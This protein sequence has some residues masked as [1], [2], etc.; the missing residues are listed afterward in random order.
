MIIA[1]LVLF[2]F[3]CDF[4]PPLNKEVLKAQ[5]F[6]TQR[7]YQKAAL[8]YQSILDKK[9]PVELQVKINYQLGDLYSIYLGKYDKAVAYYEEVLQISKDPL[10]QVKAQE[11]LGDVYFSF[12][13]RFNESAKVYKQ[14]SSFK[15]RLSNYSFYIYRF[16]LSE[17]KSGRLKSADAIFKEISEN[18]SNPHRN[19][20]LYYRAICSFEKKS[21]QQTISFLERYIRNEKRRDYIVEAKFLM[22][23]AYESMESLKNAYNIYYSIL[24]EYP[25]T[26]VIQN[27]LKGIYE[28]RVARKR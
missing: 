15:P 25:N 18:N 27:R 23:N 28:R 16:A 24:G 5:H 6:I 4:T 10:W 14:L 21:W 26:Q 20:S 22:A 1:F 12:L 11:K 17:Y 7:D 3:S 13:K 19:R 8:K 9:P 2:L